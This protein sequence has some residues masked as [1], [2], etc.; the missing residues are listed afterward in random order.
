MAQ[1]GALSLLDLNAASVCAELL[2]H[3]GSVW[4]LWPLP[5]ASGFISASADRCLPTSVVLA[6]VLWSPVAGWWLEL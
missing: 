2:P 1:D 5:D 6:S 3:Q 4:S